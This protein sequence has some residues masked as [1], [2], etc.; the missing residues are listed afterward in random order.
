MSTLLLSGS[1]RRIAATAPAP[2]KPGA[3]NAKNVRETGQFQARNIPPT[4]GPTTAPSLP[5]AMAQPTPV[6]RT[7]TGYISAANA[8]TPA[9]A[10]PAK[11]PLNVANTAIIPNEAVA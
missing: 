9:C 8:I 3:A 7:D 5:T 11:N 2:I 6:E 4:R 10:A 1:R